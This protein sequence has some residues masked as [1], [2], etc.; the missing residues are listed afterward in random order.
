[1]QEQVLVDAAARARVLGGLAGEAGGVAELAGVEPGVVVARGGAALNAGVD[2]QEGPAVLDAL[3]LVAGEAV[4][5]VA[6]EAV[7]ARVVALRVDR[8]SIDYLVNVVVELV[9]YDVEGGHLEAVGL[10]R[11]EGR[12][13]AV[14]LDEHLRE[15]FTKGVQSGLVR[16]R[17]LDH[18]LDND[19]AGGQVLRDHQLGVVD[20]EAVRRDIDGESA[21]GTHRGLRGVHH[22][23]A[24]ARSDRVLR[25]KLELILGLDAG[26]RRHCFRTRQLDGVGDVYDYI[27]QLGSYQEV[28][29][30]IL[31]VVDHPKVVKIAGACTFQVYNI[32]NMEEIYLKQKKI[33]ENT[34]KKWKLDYLEKK[35]LTSEDS[36][37]INIKKIEKK[38]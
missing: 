36:F 35:S 11:S 14:Q 32:F 16:T 25:V 13:E 5:R 33:F 18:V 8:Q 9:V 2:L 31:K 12:L 24:A 26:L 4:A 34:K 17:P 1:M 3:V 22:D 30:N 21:K 19:C 6:V 27:R 10:I 7:L 29:Q 38:N 37:L 23:D 20:G 28:K 15:G